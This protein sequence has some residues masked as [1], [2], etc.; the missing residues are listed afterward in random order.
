MERSQST[1]IMDQLVSILT[2]DLCLNVSLA[3]C[4]DVRCRVAVLENALL[5]SSF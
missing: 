1:T 2:G 5:L 4:S 3:G